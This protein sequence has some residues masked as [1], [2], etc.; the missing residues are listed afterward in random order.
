MLAGEFAPAAVI[1]AEGVP[2]FLTWATRH[3]DADE[4]APAVVGVIAGS[5]C[6]EIAARVP[7]G[8]PVYVRTHGD[9]A[10]FAY[11]ETICSSLARRCR[12]H[13]LKGAA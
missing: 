1:V 8:I 11:A 7:T 5:W 13:R 2:D 3:S 10:G 9:A 4:D 6:E 12:V